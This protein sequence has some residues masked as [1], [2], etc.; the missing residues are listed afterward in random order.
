MSE[1]YKV[2]QHNVAETVKQTAGDIIKYA[3]LLGG[4]YSVC[5]YEQDFIFATIFGIGYV[6]GSTL[7][8]NANQNISAENFSK[9]EKEL[10]RK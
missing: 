8:D 6:I 3:S 4:V 1:N 9:L 2:T 5:K 7:K 10:M